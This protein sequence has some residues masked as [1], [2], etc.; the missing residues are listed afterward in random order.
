MSWAAGACHLALL[1]LTSRLTFQKNS[2]DEPDDY[3]HGTDSGCFS[4]VLRG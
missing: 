1:R 3:G 2:F 4:L